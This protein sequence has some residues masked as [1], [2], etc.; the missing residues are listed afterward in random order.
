[1][2]YLLESC[3]TRKI[4]SFFWGE[5]LSGLILIW[6]A[7][8]NFAGLSGNKKP[9][10]L[11]P[12]KILEPFDAVRCSDLDLVWAA[13]H[14]RRDST[15]PALG[16]SSVATVVFASFLLL[17][18]LSLPPVAPI[19]P[20]PPLICPAWCLTCHRIFFCFLWSW[21]AEKDYEKIEQ[22]RNQCLTTYFSFCHFI[23]YGNFRY[24]SG[25]WW[26]EDRPSLKTPF[27]LW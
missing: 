16:N 17:L 18:S 10:A 19:P 12:G 26:R 6:C 13:R 25:T 15:K 9:R 22:N 23:V 2:T 1:M 8:L 24:K 14:G 20:A 27:I 4:C 5:T 21:I 7:W 11:F 3:I